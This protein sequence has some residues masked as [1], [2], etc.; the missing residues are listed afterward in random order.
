[1]SITRQTQQRNIVFQVLAEADR[2]LSPQEILDKGKIS[3]PS[4]GIATVYRNIKKLLNEGVLKVV[5]LPGS[6]QRY[7]IAGKDHHH[8]FHC[9]TCGRVYEIEGCAMGIEHNLPCDFELEDHVVV[10]YGRCAD[11]TSQIPAPPDERL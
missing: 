4:L 2:P 3:V 11:C 7:E 1:M 5:E 9:N 8:H 6:A 10:L